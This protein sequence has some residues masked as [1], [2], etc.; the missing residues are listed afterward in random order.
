M[1]LVTWKIKKILKTS[2]E[3]SAASPLI[4]VLILMEFLVCI[5]IASKIATILTSS[6][7]IQNILISSFY[8][9]YNLWILFISILLIIKVVQ[10]H[11]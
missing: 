11:N 7:N 8:S 3:R 5:C 4:I 9:M 2:Q 1:S 6:S 10:S